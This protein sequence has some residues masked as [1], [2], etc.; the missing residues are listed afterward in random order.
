MCRRSVAA[1][2]PGSSC[3]RGSSPS[4]NLSSHPIEKPELTPDALEERLRGLT[5]PIIA[6]IEHDQVLL[7]L[8][9]VLPEQDELLAALLN[10]LS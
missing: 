5:P 10:R 8:R 7:D 2:R 3:R 6:R 1:A 4:K 9:T